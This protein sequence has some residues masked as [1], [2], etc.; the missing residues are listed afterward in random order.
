MRTRRTPLIALLLFT[1]LAAGCSSTAPEPVS[2]VSTE[3]FETP[4]A[5]EITGTSEPMPEE[6]VAPVTEVT[7]P[8]TETFT[9]HSS[10]GERD[11]NIFVALPVA[12]AFSKRDYPVV[13]LLDGD[14]TFIW[15]AEYSRWLSSGDILPE[16]IIV[17]ID[18]STRRSRDLY[19]ENQEGVDNFLKFIQEELIPYIDDNYNTKPT[20]RTLAGISDSALFTLYALFHAPETFNRY[21]ATTPSLSRDD[22]LFEYE[23]EYARDHADLPVK[24]FL[25]IGDREPITHLEELHKRLAGRN[26]A[27]L[28]MKMVILKDHGH[29]TTIVQGFIDGLQAV[30]R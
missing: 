26:Y 29:V 6:P 2:V 28:D 5:L 20:E 25:S 19:P 30:F 13:Y 10:A 14:L 23:D 4:V 24:L 22:L 18:N 7:V 27:G 11:Y 8:R 16:T 17:G 3:T 1:L 21:I 12:Y 9:L 15:A